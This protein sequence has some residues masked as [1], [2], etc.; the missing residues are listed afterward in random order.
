[1]INVIDPSVLKMH[2]DYIETQRDYW[3]DVLG[4]NPDRFREVHAAI[5]ANKADLGFKIVKI[6]PTGDPFDAITDA[7]IPV[8][9][10]TSINKNGNGKWSDLSSE[11]IELLRSTAHLVLFHEMD[12]SLNSTRFTW[13]MMP[14]GLI[15]LLEDQ[16]GLKKRETYHQRTPSVTPS[17]CIADFNFQTKQVA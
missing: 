16:S 7:G 5:E 6:L 11:K 2:Q 17:R 14:S 10:K 12:R 3:T 15:D 13:E 1:M 9:I 4:G 8:E